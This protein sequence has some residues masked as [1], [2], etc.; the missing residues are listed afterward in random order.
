MGSRRVP[1]GHTW[2]EVV[3]LRLCSMCGVFASAPAADDAG[4]QSYPGRHGLELSGHNVRRREFIKVIAGSAA[5]CGSSKHKARL[6]FSYFMV[7]KIL[8]MRI[9]PESSV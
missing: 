5:A 7:G 4:F 1:G 8:L 6:N 2:R 9:R 3:L